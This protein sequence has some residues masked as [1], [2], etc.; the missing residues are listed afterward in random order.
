MELGRFK[1][2]LF[3]TTVIF[4]GFPQVQGDGWAEPR[5]HPHVSLGPIEV[6]DLVRIP[7]LSVIRAQG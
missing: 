3:Q 1:S 6:V 7:L 4:I 2:C 5:L